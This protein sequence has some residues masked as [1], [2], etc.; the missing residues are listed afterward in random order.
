MN[1]AILD[2]D[3][4]GV[5]LGLEEFG[6][7][8]KY[9]RTSSDEVLDRIKDVCIVVTNK[10]VLDE[11]ILSEATNL[12]L[13]AITATGMNNVD[14][15]YCEKN[16][17]EVCNVVG[18]STHSVTEHTLAMYFYLNSKLYHY[19]KYGKE[20][21][22]DSSIFT[23]LSHPF[24]GL[25]TKTWGIIGMGNIGRSVA[26]AVKG[27]DANVQYYSTT[28]KNTKHEYVCVGL[29][30]LLQTSDVVSIHCPLNETTKNLIAYD[31]LAMM[32]QDAI[33]INVARGGIVCEDS[34]KK[35]LDDGMLG[36]LGLDV[37]TQE[38]PRDIDTSF[39]DYERVLVTP[40]IAWASNEARKILAQT[41]KQNI[42]DYLKTKS[43][44]C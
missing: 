14:L 11:Q 23:D 25:A 32:K 42:K 22:K 40:H 16:N 4:I 17:I 3:V 8:Q 9:A 19:A 1:I 41:V 34:L 12:R 29:Q 30:E 33:L 44:S 2:Q 10:V 21:W 7:V 39:F 13:I 26:M 20:E 15:Q 5:D 18:Y 24:S 31:E 35:A 43:D 28:Q 38:P 6:N 27:L 36:G 37:L